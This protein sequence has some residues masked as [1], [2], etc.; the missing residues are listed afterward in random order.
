MKRE[1][2]DGAATCQA[3]GK[4]TYVDRKTARRVK[5]RIHDSELRIYHC[6]DCEAA[7]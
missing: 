3:T 4:R 7:S 1:H 2:W 5:S 6:D